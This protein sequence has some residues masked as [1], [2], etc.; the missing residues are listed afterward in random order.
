MAIYRTQ[1][2]K[3]R[4]LGLAKQDLIAD[5]NDIIALSKNYTV[6]D[7]T[8]LLLDDA[9]ADTVNNIY[10][11]QVAPPRPRPKATPA[12]A[13]EVA[14]APAPKAPVPSENKPR[15]EARKNSTPRR[16]D[17]DGDGSSIPAI[18]EAMLQMIDRL[19]ARNGGSSADDVITGKVSFDNLDP[20]L[21]QRLS[22]TQ[23][24]AYKI[25]DNTAPSIPASNIP[26]FQKIVDD[27]VLGQNVYLKGGA[28]TGKTT[29]AQKVAKALG[30]DFTTINCSQWTAP[31][32]IIG[33]QT[34]DGYQEGKLIKA[35][36]EG[37]VLVLDEL[38]KLDPNTAGLL[39]EALAKAKLPGEV[40]FNARNER[41]VKHPNFAVIG[42]GN[43]WPISESVT[44]G[45]NNKQDLSLL[46]R[47]AGCVYTIEKNP[48]L[49]KQVVGSE[50]L[51]GYCDELRRVIEKLKYEQQI[52]MRFMMTCRDTLILELQRL[53]AGKQ[54]A[55]IGKTLCDCFTSFL[56][57][58]FS[59]LQQETIKKEFK[60]PGLDYI[61]GKHYRGESK[62]FIQAFRHAGYWDTVGVNGLRGFGASFRTYSSFE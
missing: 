15:P 56:E 37:L 58:N 45:A 35:W 57:V 48:E 30:R 9:L 34:M 27:L 20:D 29:L 52:S 6:D 10:G 51:W 26:E 25:N 54:E 43:I 5:L 18:R 14:P 55:N 7:L 36:S 21:Q 19:K 44:Y 33:G 12:S 4:I 61:L 50:T 3:D 62:L 38:P 47:F 23:I 60:S 49:E 11:F 31:T 1:A 32:E 46:D 2:I 39:N 24:I 42:T 22:N 41:F 13:P 8:A 40:I 59:P 28:G 17:G 53:E 16:A